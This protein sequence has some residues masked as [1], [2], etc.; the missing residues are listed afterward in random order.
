MGGG[1]VFWP[2]IN[3]SALELLFTKGVPGEVYNIGA[4]N[5]RSNLEVV[6]MLLKML[7]KPESLMSH[8][9]DRP[10]HDRRY[11]IDATKMHKLGWSP[12]YPREKF[13]EGLRKTVEW[14]Q[15]NTE[16]VNEVRKKKSEMNPHI[17]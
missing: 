15:T 3:A 6:R 5:E 12:E 1:G 14:Y 9:Q 17:K 4:D 8:V 11:A 13:E 7:G 2:F 10:G 16:W